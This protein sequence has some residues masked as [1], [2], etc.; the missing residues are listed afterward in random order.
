MV[1]CHFFKRFLIEK[2]KEQQNHLST[3][4]ERNRW[5]RTATITDY[6]KKFPKAG[7]ARNR[8]VWVCG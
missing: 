2:I 8:G 5:T 4:H 6:E 3:R 1:Q 7:L